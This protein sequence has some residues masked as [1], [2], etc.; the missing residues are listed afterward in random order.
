MDVF[1]L[2]DVHRSFHRVRIRLSDLREEDFMTV[3]R[4][5][6]SEVIA[7]KNKLSKRDERDFVDLILDEIAKALVRKGGQNDRQPTFS[8]RKNYATA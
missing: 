7:S 5:S 3:T 8:F 2:C 4:T 6:L 1:I